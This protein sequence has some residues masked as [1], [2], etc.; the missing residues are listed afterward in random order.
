M[1]ACTPYVAW[2][3]WAVHRNHCLDDACTAAMLTGYH[4]CSAALLAR[5]GYLRMD[6]LSGACGLSNW[7][8][9]RCLER[10]TSTSVQQ[11]EAGVLIWGFNSGMRL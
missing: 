1:K 9:R 11:D 4:G 6:P 3:L 8:S 5:D 2:I 7:V 10:V